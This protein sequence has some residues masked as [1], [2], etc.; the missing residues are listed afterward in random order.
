MANRATRLLLVIDRTM[1]ATGDATMRTALQE[2]RTMLVA[3]SAVQGMALRKPAGVALG[4]RPRT[5]AMAPA[6][7]SQAWSLAS[8]AGRTEGDGEEVAV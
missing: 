5:G 2:A 6:R 4:V 1:A 3:A 8:E 7:R